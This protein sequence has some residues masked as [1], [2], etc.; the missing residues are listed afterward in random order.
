[1]SRVEATY[2]LAKQ[3][4]DKGMS[5]KEALEVAKY[6]VDKHPTAEFFC[7]MREM[8]EKMKSLQNE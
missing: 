1:M 5:A 6:K 2:R 3:L 7:W 4:M 8:R